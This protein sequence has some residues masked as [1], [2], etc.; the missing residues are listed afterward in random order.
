MQF[1]LGMHPH[2]ASCSQWLHL[3][4]GC[5]QSH[6][7]QDSKSLLAPSAGVALWLAL[8]GHIHLLFAWFFALSGRLMGVRATAF[9]FLV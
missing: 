9:S 1:G 3:W 5:C 4:S 6:W 2:V 7:A 8:N